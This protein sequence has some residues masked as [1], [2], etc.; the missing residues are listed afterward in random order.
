MKQKY[1]EARIHFGEP[2]FSS[3]FAEIS[4]LFGLLGLGSDTGG[5]SVHLAEYQ[6]R[7]FGITLVGIDPIVARR[8]FRVGDGQITASPGRSSLVSTG[9]GILIERDFELLVS[10]HHKSFTVVVC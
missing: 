5:S 1:L 8:K 2:D 6:D 10:F 7:I 9:L 3:R 4:D